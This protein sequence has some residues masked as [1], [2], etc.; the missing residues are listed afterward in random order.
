[1]VND[2]SSTFSLWIAE[3]ALTMA[4]VAGAATGPRSRGN[5]DIENAGWRRAF[6]GICT[7]AGVSG[8]PGRFATFGG[9]AMALS[10][11]ANLPGERRAAGLD[12]GGVGVDCYCVT[13]VRS[14]AVHID[15]G[16]PSTEP[17]RPGD[18]YLLDLAS[19]WAA[20]VA[21]QSELGEVSLYVPRQRLMQSGPRLDVTGWKRTSDSGL[22]QAIGAIL[23][24]LGR[25]VECLDSTVFSACAGA[26]ADMA[27]ADLRK[28]ASI[29]PRVHGAVEQGTKLDRIRRFIDRH[30]HSDALTPDLIAGDFALSRAVLYR[31]FEPW[32]GVTTYIRNQ[33]MARVLH[34]LGAP[35]PSRHRISTLARRY[36]YKNAAAFTRA[37]R[38][39]YGFAPREVASR[40]RAIPGGD[41]LI[42]FLAPLCGR[43]PPPT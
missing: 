7:V 31:M 24:M 42:D 17:S 38:E 41:R 6:D 16:R 28:T 11:A 43:V 15:N 2:T 1:M 35:G 32:G 5:S 27:L 39:T 26:I 9:Q 34:E 10:V 22:G 20:R 29:V 3:S 18:V 30:L 33:R 12:V 40:P 21:D 25:Q 4:N 8:E 19:P 37:F 36:G 14:G 13:L 23:E